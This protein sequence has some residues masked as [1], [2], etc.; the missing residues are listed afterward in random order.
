MLYLHLQLASPGAGLRVLHDSMHP[1]G[2]PQS[3]LMHFL[4][5]FLQP[6]INC[7]KPG[8]HGELPVQSHIALAPHT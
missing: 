8:S 4:A 1:C 7:D 5:A 6:D 3:P 2:K